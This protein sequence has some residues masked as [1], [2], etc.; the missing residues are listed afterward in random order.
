M[1]TKKMRNIN[2]NNKSRSIYHPFKEK[3]WTGV[4]WAKVEKTISNLQHRITKARSRGDYR[5]VR[6][7]QRLLTRN[8][9]GRLK[10]V[11][12]VAQENPGKQTPGIDGE[13]WTTPERKLQAALELRKKSPT[14]PLR[15]TSIPS[16]GF[17]NVL[18]PDSWF[19][20]A[21]T[22]RYPGKFLLRKKLVFEE[23]KITQKQSTKGPRAWEGSNGQKKPFGISCMNDRAR[24]AVWKLAL[25]PCV[26]ATSDPQGYGCR[27]YRGCW[28]AHAQ[29]RTLLKNN[30]CL[31]WVLKTRIE[32]FSDTIYHD[33]L[34]KNTPMEKKIL[35]SWLKS[36]SLENGDL[37]V[38]P[39][40]G[41][42]QRPT[43]ERTPLG[44]PGKV[45]NF[46]DL[47]TLGQGQG[48]VISTTLA[49][50]ALTGLDNY[51]KQSFK[52][53]PIQFENTTTSLR[54]LG[55]NVVRY[56]DDMIITGSSKHQLESVKT[57]V[58]DFLNIRGLN[59][60]E[61]KTEI[62]SI[63]QGFDFLDWNFRRYSKSNT[64]LCKI[65]KNSLSR[66]CQEIK[67]ITKT[68]H[69]AIQLI[70]KINDKVV[71]WTN[72][73]RC[74]NGIAKVWSKLNCY[75]YDLLMK[76]GLRHHSNKT[77]KWIYKNYWKKINGRMAFSI[78]SKDKT[79]TIKP[80]KLC[81]LEANF[82]K[83]KTGVRKDGKAKFDD[84]TLRG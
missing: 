52:P 75:T 57:A 82:P 15:R 55:I 60:T 83:F 9:S 49:N 70:N 12:M 44:W 64:F 45:A 48:G 36:G 47:Q 37:F 78:T 77:K 2:Q 53:G 19:E 84:L 76:W 39:L 13:L 32:K 54:S 46:Q 65:S 16:E 42:R 5:K 63:Y 6:D 62:L 26:V 18:A 38:L 3:Q 71:W 51:L 24:Q 72:Y 7:L 21:Q 1:N 35:K 80:Y 69:C 56:A 67:Y 79:Y 22:S 74:C 25:E 40:Q 8:I 66:H 30:H 41:K 11:R 10:G 81:F 61:Q 20:H 17:A 27:P 34:L 73:H 59:I 23:A 29:I 43:E 68:T 50:F 14:K 28:E 4:N 58:K 33:W 31:M